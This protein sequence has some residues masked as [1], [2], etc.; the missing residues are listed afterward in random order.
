M[1]HGEIQDQ[2]T[3]RRQTVSLFLGCLEDYVVLYLNIT[4]V[5]YQSLT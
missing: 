3:R 1:G 4:P 5:L 2:S